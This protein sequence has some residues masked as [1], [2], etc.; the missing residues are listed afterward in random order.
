MQ[1]LRGVVGLLA[2][3]WVRTIFLAVLAEGLLMYGALAFVPLHLHRM[4]E[5]SVGASGALILLFAAGGL[6]YSLSAGWL[7]PRLGE[8]GISGLGG[9]SMALGTGLIAIAPNT[10]VGMVGLFF[11]GAGFYSFHN[12]LQTNATQMAPDARGSAVSLFAFGLFGGSSLGVLAGG[13]VV[14][15]LGTRPLLLAASAGLVVLT[16]FFSGRL[17]SRGEAR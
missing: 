2:R 17:P 6:A 14:D 7:V 9:A 3:P 8:R 11:A 4:L 5:L 1:D 12:T 16:V 13:L 15:A 10:V